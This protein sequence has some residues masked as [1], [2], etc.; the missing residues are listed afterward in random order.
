MQYNYGFT[1]YDYGNGNALTVHAAL[2]SDVH[3]HEELTSDFP[4]R[5]LEH[6][7]FHPVNCYLK[8]AYF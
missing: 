1:I 5:N 2:V 3:W 6:L 7:A 4:D 8:I